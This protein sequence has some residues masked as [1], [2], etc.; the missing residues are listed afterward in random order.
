MCL[1]IAELLS[2]VAHDCNIALAFCVFMLLLV[3]FA[4]I[5]YLQ[6]SLFVLFGEILPFNI[7]SHT[8]IHMSEILPSTRVFCFKTT[9]TRV[10][11]GFCIINTLINI[12]MYLNM[13]IAGVWN[14]SFV[15]L[16]IMV[17]KML[18][19]Q[20]W[21]IFV[22]IMFKNINDMILSQTASPEV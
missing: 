3:D 14:E 10:Q 6:L 8:A 1:R 12:A 2:D 16:I 19:S 4:A 7:I 9:P 11:C 20:I 15:L 18:F 17:I 5:S 13:L 22:K 21:K